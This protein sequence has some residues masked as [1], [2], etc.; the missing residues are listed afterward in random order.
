MQGPALALFEQSS[1]SSSYST[2]HCLLTMLLSLQYYIAACIDCY[3]IMVSPLSDEVQWIMGQELLNTVAIFTLRDSPIR[4]SPYT[5][6]LGRTWKGFFKAFAAFSLML[7]GSIGVMCYQQSCGRLN[8]ISVST[9]ILLKF[10]EH[11]CS[12]VASFTSSPQWTFLFMSFWCFLISISMPNS[13]KRDMRREITG[14]YI[15]LGLV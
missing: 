14:V 12:M 11:L 9:T 13:V 6:G 10:G 5:N 1:L 7:V 4:T 2:V 15:T 3:I 8:N